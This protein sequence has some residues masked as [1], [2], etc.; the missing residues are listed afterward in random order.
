[1]GDQGQTGT[2]S[3]SQ[4]LQWGW[5]GWLQKQLIPSHRTM[6]MPAPGL[7]ETEQRDPRDKA[8]LR[9]WTLPCTGACRSVTMWQW[10]ATASDV[11][12]APAKPSCCCFHVS[13]EIWSS[14]CLLWPEITEIRIL[15][16]VVPVQL[17]WYSANSLKMEISPLRWV[18]FLKSLRYLNF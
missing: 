9:A 1:M 6:H 8:G 18:H 16:N 5:C 14:L 12:H 7:T 10:A 13:F 4:N 3:V 2:M 11:L 17:N 15:G